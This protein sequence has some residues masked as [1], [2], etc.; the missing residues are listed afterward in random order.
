MR[1]SGPKRYEYSRVADDWIYPRDNQSIG[2]LLNDELGRVLEQ[3]I[4][5]RL[6]KISKTIS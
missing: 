3:D 1:F 2:E 4:D 6:A 5:L